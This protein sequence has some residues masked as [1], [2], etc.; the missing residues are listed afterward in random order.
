MTNQEESIAE[1]LEIRKRKQKQLKNLEKELKKEKISEEIGNKL[2]REIKTDIEDIRIRL[3]SILE[4]NCIKIESR[5]NDLK[6]KN[7]K[8]SEGLGAISKL[9]EENEA[10]LKI[11]QINRIQFHQNRRN[12]EKEKHTNKKNISENSMKIQRL[13]LLLEKTQGMLTIE[14]TR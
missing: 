6:E 14:K 5:I 7:E 12:Y 2:R 9:M 11:K 10:R 13:S 8:L 3:V 4:K 1:L